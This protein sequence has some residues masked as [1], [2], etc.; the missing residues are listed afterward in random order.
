MIERST[1]KGMLF[2]KKSNYKGIIIFIIFILIIDILFFPVLM[3]RLLSP[4]LTGESLYEDLGILN[5][6]GCFVTVDRIKI[7][8]GFEIII[9]SLCGLLLTSFNKTSLIHN[10]EHGSARLLTDKEFYELLP[11]YYFSNKC[12]SLAFPIL[13]YEE[14]R[15]K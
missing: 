12:D 13:S 11:S 2:M 8:I 9:L 14:K 7:T 1:M 10:N 6:S 4:L 15:K 5:W 3:N